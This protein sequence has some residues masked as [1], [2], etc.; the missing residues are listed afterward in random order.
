MGVVRS[1]WE[2]ERGRISNIQHGIFNDEGKRDCGG[3]RRETT[4]CAKGREN[5][6]VKGSVWA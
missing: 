6:R 1:T 5:G 2:V 3:R 4:K